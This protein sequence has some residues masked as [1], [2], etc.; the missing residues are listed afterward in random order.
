MENLRKHR[1][2]KIVT[3]E[4]RRN[5]A[6]SKPNYHTTTFFTE[7]LLTIEMKRKTAT[8]MNK[9]IYLGLSILQLSKLFMYGFWYDYVKPK[10]GEKA[11]LCYMDIESFTVYKKTDYIYK[12][13]GED[14]ETRF[15][16]S[17]YEL[18]RALP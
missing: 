3:T 14:A 4:R 1:E 7:H 12:D 10:Y 9:H 8:F 13:I 15:H 17:N 6:V 2:I 11:K 16:T 5:Y 18:E